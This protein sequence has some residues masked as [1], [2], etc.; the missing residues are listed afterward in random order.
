[1]TQRPRVLIYRDHL[2]PLSETFVVNQSLGLERFEAFLVGSK[3]GHP[4]RIELPRDRFRLLNHGGPRGFVREVLF[5]FFGIIPRDV[6]AWCRSLRPVLVHAHFGPDG[7]LA[8]PLA[9]RLKVPLVVSYHGSDATIKDEYVWGSPI[10]HRLYRLRRKKL[11]VTA[12][13]FITP[14]RFVKR[15]AVSRQ[16]IPEHKIVVIPHGIDLERFTPGNQPRYGRILFVG[17]LVELKGLHHL[18]EAVSRIQEQFPEL[19]LVVVGDGP[20]RSLYENLA[21]RKLGARCRFLGAQPHDAVR[22]EMQKAYVF[23]MPSISMPNGEAESFGMVF[24]EAQACGLP[25]VAYAVGGIPEVVAHGTTGFLAEEGDV[26]ALAQYLKA[27]LEDPD[28]RD[29]MGRAGPLWVKA[30]FDRRRQ[31]EALENLYRQVCYEGGWT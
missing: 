30:H 15:M 25:V 27:F 20:D 11:A 23:S 6:L 17:R 12:R 21:T 10:G 14:S 28:L 31:N 13:A 16:G 18:I 5:K 24:L 1:M 3:P 26:T 29:E 9:E 7:T 2:L 19:H 4:P 8:M 22:D